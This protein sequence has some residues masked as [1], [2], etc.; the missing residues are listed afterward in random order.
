MTGD[1]LLE[2]GCEEIP[3]GFLSRAIAE[4]PGIARDK[5]AAARLT[6]GE[7]VALGAPRR[8]A[9]F[10]PG[11]AERQPDI[12]ETV[13]GPPASVAFDKEGKPTKAGVG[14]A[15]KNGVPVEALTVVDVPGKGSYVAARREQKG[16]ETRALLPKLLVEIIRAI[17]WKKSMR[18]AE[19]AE[20]FVRPVHWIVALFGGEVVPIDLFGVTSGRETHGHRFLAPGAI[21]L[22]GSLDD[23]QHKLRAAFVIVDPL[24]RRTAIEAELRRVERDTGVKI[25]PDE[26]LVAEVTNLVEYPHAICGDFD[27]RH[28]EIPAEVIV[29]AMRGHQRYFAAEA[30]DGK[31]A[32]HFVTIAGTLVKD[33]KVVQHGNE[34]VLAAR[35]ADARAS[36]STRIARTSWKSARPG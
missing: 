34:R 15:A 25:R 32:A 10:V 7:I 20:A 36:S 18:W 2:I 35:L 23:Y 19:E 11:L 33:P 30:G 21:A 29:S 12:A 8:L 14:F 6:H 31:L 5:L 13:T 1:L 22:D 16:E 9:I 27:A 28:L 17:P 3:A 26:D 24:L 4:A